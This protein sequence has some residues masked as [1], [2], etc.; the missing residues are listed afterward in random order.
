MAAATNRRN[1]YARNRFKQLHA[2]CQTVRSG[3]VS[4]A[5]ERMYLSQPSVSLLIKALEQGLGT[6]LFVRRGSRLQLTAEGRILHELAEPL[7]RD[8]DTLAD[9]FVERCKNIASGKL[10]IAASESTILYV[11]PSVIKGYAERFPRIRFKLHTVTGIEGLALLRKREVDVVVGALT[12]VPA[13]VEYSALLEYQPVLIVPRGHPLGDRP[14]PSLADVSAYPL[15]LPPRHLVTW[16]SVEE[17]FRE[18][19]L[20]YSVAVEASSWEVI[21]QYVE[22]GLGISIVASICLQGNENLTVRALGHEFPKQRYGVAL[23]KNRKPSPATQKFIALL[24]GHCL[25]L[26]T[27]ERRIS[28]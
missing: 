13:D 8:L 26:N 21:K 14:A 1:H 23:L 5:A 3:T 18:L 25:Q 9:V 7:I 24:R 27:P 17:S 11:L 6:P 2:F 4:A 22:A 12:E 19:A 15:I 20:G 16:R 10:D 28:R